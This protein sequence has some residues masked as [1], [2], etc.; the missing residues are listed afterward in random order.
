[1]G[2]S[3]IDAYTA[4][5]SGAGLKTWGSPCRQGEGGASNPVLLR[6][7]LWRLSSLLAGHRSAL[8]VYGV[9][10]PSLL[11]LLPHGTYFPHSADAKQPLS[12]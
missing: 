11:N 10:C 8:G 4:C 7:K 12:Y 6:E 9:T 3:K 2:F 1:M 5:L